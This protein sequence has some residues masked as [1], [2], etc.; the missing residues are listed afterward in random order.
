MAGFTLEIDQN[1]SGIFGGGYDQVGMHDA[2][3][4]ADQVPATLATKNPKARTHNLSPSFIQTIGRK[5]QSFPL[6]SVPS[7]IWRE[8]WGIELIMGAVYRK[9]LITM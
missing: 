2:Y 3:V 6:Y 4:E 5:F 7:G 9:A 1:P 8:K